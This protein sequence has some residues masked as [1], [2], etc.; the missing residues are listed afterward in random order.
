VVQ[1][2][3]GGNS[4]LAAILQTLSALRVVEVEDK[5]PIRPGCVYLAPADYHLLV[6]PGRFALSTEGPLAYT[7]PSIDV[8][9]ESAA[10]AYGPGVIGV[11]LTGGNRDG[12]QGAARIKARSGR[13]IVQDPATAACPIMPAA[14]IAATTV[15]QVLPL[16]EIGPGLVAW[17][18]NPAT[19]MEGTTESWPTPES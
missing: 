14:V 13:I 7:R 2:R 17:C 8:L 15:D 6:E 4:V 10:W 16:P 9:F 1:H 19:R 12:A 3:R 11:I 5:T 18:A